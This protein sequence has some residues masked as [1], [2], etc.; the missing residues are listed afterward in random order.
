MIILCVRSLLTPRI[1]FAP[2]VAPA[3][4]CSARAKP[5]AEDPLVVAFLSVRITNISPT[6]VVIY[7]YDGSEEDQEVRPG[8]Y[9]P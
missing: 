6:S 8:L 7:Q 5:Q 3:L 1:H 9:C 4:V 2:S